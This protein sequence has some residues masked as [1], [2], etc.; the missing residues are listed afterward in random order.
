MTL[1]K[2]IAL[3]LLCGACFAAVQA[4]DPGE[5]DDEFP[6]EVPPEEPQP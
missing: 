2:I 4:I 3:L 6:C 1:K 5:G